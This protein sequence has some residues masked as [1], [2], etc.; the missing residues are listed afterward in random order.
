MNID[1]RKFIKGMAAATAAMPFTSTF[2]SVLTD[3]PEINYPIAFFTKPLDSFEISFMAE[4]LAEAGI[5]G[6]DLTVRPRGRVEPERV[7]DELP[8]VI[9]AGKKNGLITEM[10]V[11]S[12]KSVED[13]YAK[14]VLRTAAGQGIKHYRLGYYNYDFK[15]GI[16]ESLDQIKGEMKQLAQFNKETG[17]QAGYQNHAGTRFGAPMWDVWN[18]IKDLPSDDISSQF[19]IRHAVTEGSS[20]WILAL[21]LLKKNIGSLAIKDFTWDVSTGK[22]KIVS[23]PLGEGIVDFDLFFKTIKELNIHAPISLHAEYPLLT[24]EEES[25]SLLQR[26]KILIAKIKKDVDFIRMYLDK[27]QLI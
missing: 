8:L 14:P 18:V 3:V 17:I 19:D 26:Q 21:H 10:M 12:I 7:K 24:E 6:F 27:Y 25:L 13:K 1:R 22:A 16:A 23:V 11:T 15:Q 20:S 4:T 5:N 9:E 2:A